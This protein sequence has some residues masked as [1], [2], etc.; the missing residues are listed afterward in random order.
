M[1][2]RHPGITPRPCSNLAYRLT[3]FQHLLKPRRC[4]W[5]FDSSRVSNTSERRQF[6]DRAAG[7]LP[8]QALAT[9][10]AALVCCATRAPAQFGVKCD[11]PSFA[12]APDGTKLSED[13]QAAVRATC[14]FN[15][16]NTEIRETFGK[17][18]W[19]WDL[20]PKARA[21]VSDLT[22]L[23][24]VAAELNFKTSDQRALG[25]IRRMYIRVGERR[26]W[27]ANEERKFAIRQQKLAVSPPQAGG[28]ADSLAAAESA[29]F[30]FV[31]FQDGISNGDKDSFL[32]AYGALIV[33][34]PNQDKSYRLSLGAPVPRDQLRLVLDSMKSQKEIVRTAFARW[35]DT[36]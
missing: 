21:D 15:M 27:L 4:F 31:V 25:N 9:A 7:V 30:V 19:S 24:D 10:L 8:W 20:L 28:S 17:A 26:R 23:A 18:G 5:S 36:E 32:R 11:S 22:N 6:T 34:G 2:F 16:K 13:M 33:D 3:R 14:I 12:T 35:S 1:M 29:M